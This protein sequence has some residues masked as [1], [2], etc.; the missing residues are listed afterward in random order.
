MDVKGEAPFRADDPFVPRD[1]VDV[2]DMP[3]FIFPEILPP[4]APRH[5]RQ[6]VGRYVCRSLTFYGPQARN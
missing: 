5:N 2:P 6:N 3:I 4:E 1:G